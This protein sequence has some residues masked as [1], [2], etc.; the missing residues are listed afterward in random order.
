MARTLPA[1]LLK[2]LLIP[3]C[4]AALSGCSTAP[5]ST[6]TRAMVAVPQTAFYKYGPA[7]SFGPDFLLTQN[8]KVTVLKRD[9]AFTRVLMEDGT[10]GYIASEDLKAAPPEPPPQ[11][12]GSSSGVRTTS[13]G[14]PR[15]SNVQSVPDSPL[16]DMT[17]LP[18]LPAEA[19]PAKPAPDFRF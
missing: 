12:R 17:D 16:F 14:K 19:E 15:R 18:A 5:A 9:W 6:G 8:A 4:L 11:A 1:H 13:S 10:A 2:C 7:Q 3:M